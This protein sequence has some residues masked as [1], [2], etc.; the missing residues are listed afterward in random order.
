MALYD[1]AGRITRRA[2]EGSIAALFAF[3]LL[4]AISRFAIRLH[5]QRRLSWDD[6][7][8]LL[9]ILLLIS[10]LVIMFDFIDDL[11]LMQSL[12]SGQF[13]LDMKVSAIIPK[14]MRLHKSIM[15]FDVLVWCSFNAVK[16]SFLFFFKDITAR[17]GKLRLYWL[18][19][20]VFTLLDWAVG[21]P[22][23]FVLCPHFDE[24]ALTC[25]FGTHLARAVS[26]SY[27][28]CLLNLISDLMIISIPLL[29]LRKVMIPIRTKIYLSL[30][31]CLSFVTIGITIVRIYS[32]KVPGTET[33]DLQWQVYW[34]VV[35]ACV[36]IIVVSM[37]AFRMLFVHRSTRSASKGAV[38]A[39]SH[40][41]HRFRRQHI[42]ITDD[43]ANDVDLP[44]R[45]PAA[46][47]TGVQTFINE[48][49]NTQLNT[50]SRSAIVSG[51]SAYKESLSKL[52][53]IHVGYV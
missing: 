42:N 20:T 22:L 21:I 10:C 53:K 31:L 24:R 18:A 4:A 35:E 9:A 34:C 32:I 52:K 49:G 29:I 1:N 6:G 27:A 47:M 8:L 46:T 40:L 30:S 13:T 41:G 14:A 2:A 50:G 15:A 17:T 25:L 44:E 5:Y 51:D 33:Y 39:Q 36:G 12:I 19:V 45:F 3:S 11:Y 37:T 7:W 26:V 48:C 28:L 43:L 16:F 23:N 38:P